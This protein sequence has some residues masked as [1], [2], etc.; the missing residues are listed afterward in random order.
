MV[1]LFIS[2]PETIVWPLVVWRAPRY[3]NLFLTSPLVFWGY[4]LGS[5][6][7]VLVGSV[8]ISVTLIEPYLPPV[9]KPKPRVVVWTH[10]GRTILT[11]REI[12][13]LAVAEAEIESRITGEKM[14]PHP[15]FYGFFVFDSINFWMSR[16]V[17]E[18]L[19]KGC[20]V[21]ESKIFVPKFETEATSPWKMWKLIHGTEAPA[22]LA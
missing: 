18:R 17:Y 7:I 16:Q 22:D 9:S 13:D 21:E 20:I 15:R 1:I 6:T 5:L 8:L 4:I 14:L 12:F 10:N 19:V 3:L 11:T 2:S